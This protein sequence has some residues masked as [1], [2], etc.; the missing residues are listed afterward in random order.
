MQT[1]GDTTV[2]L[3]QE[4][5]LAKIRNIAAE[6]EREL[7]KH[8]EEDQGSSAGTGNKKEK[9][10]KKSQQQDKK[11]QQ[12]QDKKRKRDEEC[13]ED[14]EYEE[15]EVRVED[16]KKVFTSSRTEKQQE[17]LQEMQFIKRLPAS[18]LIAMIVE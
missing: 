14:K 12:Q 8:L 10:K 18:T 6:M 17:V 13:K 11:D 16:G 3:P 7:S 2:V 9:E 4:Q 15:D 5:E 1:P